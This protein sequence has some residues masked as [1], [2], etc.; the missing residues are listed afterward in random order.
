MCYVL[1]DQQFVIG[2]LLFLF[3]GVYFTVRCQGSSNLALD[4]Q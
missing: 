3:S 1:M 4:G 2:Y